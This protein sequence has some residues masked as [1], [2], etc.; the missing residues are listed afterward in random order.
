MGGNSAS[1]YVLWPNDCGTPLALRAAPAVTLSL[2]ES[3][4]AD[5]VEVE[6]GCPSVLMPVPHA[7][8]A[9]SY[10]NERAVGIGSMLINCMYVCG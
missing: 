7:L 8:P 1:D 10:R 4:R 3:A 2:T 9:R 6:A 5:R